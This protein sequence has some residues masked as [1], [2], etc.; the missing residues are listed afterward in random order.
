MRNQNSK[1][2]DYSLTMAIKFCV[3]SSKI[4]FISQDIGYLFQAPAAPGFT[5]FHNEFTF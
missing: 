1:G 3:F 5:S 2:E 4:V